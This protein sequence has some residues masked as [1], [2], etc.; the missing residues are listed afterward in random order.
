MPQ[1]YTG[2]SNGGARGYSAAWAA[3][4]LLVLSLSREAAQDRVDGV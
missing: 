4:W 3:R 2:L 1:K